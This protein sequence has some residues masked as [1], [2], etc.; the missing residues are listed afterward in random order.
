[1]DRD[2]RHIARVAIAIAMVGWYLA[3]P[4]RAPE[5]GTADAD[6]AAPTSVWDY[7]KTNAQCEQ[8]RMQLSGDPVLGARMKAGKCLPSATDPRL[9]PK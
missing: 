2:G 1:M 6:P 9:K 7:Y 4:V 8:M 3:V 5:P